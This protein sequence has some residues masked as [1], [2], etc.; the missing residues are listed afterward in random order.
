MFD[1][2]EIRDGVRR[3]EERIRPHV[4]ETAIQHSLY[5]SDLGR[6]VVYCKL[7]NL[8]HTGSFKV[9]GAMNKLLSLSERERTRGAV[10]ASTGNHGAAVAF[11]AG[12]LGA[13]CTVFVPE[14]ADAAKV[15]SIE[16]L[17]G[18][19][20]YFGEDT[21][22]TEVFARQYAVENGLVYVSPYNDR[23]VIEGQGTIGLELDRQL[24]N[25]GAV[26]IAVGGGGLIS[27]VAG[28]LKSLHPD[29]R[30]VGCSPENSQVM[31]QS[32]RTGRILDLPSLP[33]LSDGTAGGI[34]ADSITFDMCRELVDEFVTVTEEE[35]KEQLR[36]FIRNHDMIIEG[37]AAVA[38]ASYL[39]TCEKVAGR[40][41]VVLICGGN[42]NRETLSTIL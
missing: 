26:F 5:L 24:D 10:A 25:V 32:I 31:I 9:R 3:A 35:I 23:D 19:I 28:Y 21:V 22:E 40:N 8:Q 6:A 1:A 36:L 38:A 27:G 12:R 30:I 39:K 17:G 34:E 11:S 42:I 13:R 16:R 20:R 37:A 41:V 33:T 2:T 14:N 18:E 7:E 29:V 15:K 4:L